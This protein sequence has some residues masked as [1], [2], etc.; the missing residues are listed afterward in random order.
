MKQGALFLTAIIWLIMGQSV[1]AQI[2]SPQDI[3]GLAFWVD[4]QDVNGTGIQPANGG[5]FTIWVDKS[6]GGNNLT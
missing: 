1:Y 2:S 5:V 3:A 4:A 6:A